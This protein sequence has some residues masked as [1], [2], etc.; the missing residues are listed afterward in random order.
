MT[1]VKVCG[2]TRESD[3]RTAADLGADALGFILA[4]SPR[5]V[6]LDRA[7]NLIRGLSP[8]V[9]RVA[10]L[11]DPTKGELREIVESRLFDCLQFHGREEPGLLAEVPLKTIKAFGVS[12]REDL[13][14]TEPYAETADFFLFDTKTGNASGGTGQAFDWS[15]LAGRPFPRPFILAGGLGPENLKEALEKVHPAAVD[16]NSRLE[17][18]PGVKDPVLMARAILAVKKSERDD[19]RGEL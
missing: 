15:V 19:L 9:T 18:A 8:F 4:R 14:R 2:L 11:S 3:V 1:R 5:R 12:C 17:T 13:D 10:V 7:A 16:L 6:T